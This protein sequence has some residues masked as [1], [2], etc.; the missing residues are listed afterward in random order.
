MS[1]LSTVPKKRKRRVV[2]G[3]LGIY[4]PKNHADYITLYC[5]AHNVTKTSIML[6]LISNWVTGRKQHVYTESVLE[7]KIAQKAFFVWKNTKGESF[8]TF[9]TILKAELKHKKLDVDT[10]GRILKLLE[11]E[12][13]KNT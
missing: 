10:V 13:S 8:D 7:Q 2:V 11:D 1:I 3:F 6:E 9:K 4:I 5:N 12:Q